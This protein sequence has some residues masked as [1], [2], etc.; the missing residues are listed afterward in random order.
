VGSYSTQAAQTIREEM[1]AAGVEL[2]AQPPRLASI[3]NLERGEVRLHAV[4]PGPALAEGG[5][6]RCDPRPHASMSSS[7]GWPIGQG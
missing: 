4:D 1:A 5:F 6:E 2:F 3:A 7:R